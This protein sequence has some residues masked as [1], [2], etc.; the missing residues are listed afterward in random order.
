MTGSPPGALRVMWVLSRVGLSRW[1]GRLSG[2]IGRLRKK[3]RKAGPAARQPTPAK[4]TVSAW[5]TGVFAVMFLFTGINLAATCVRGLG[6]ACEG[7]SPGHFGK[8]GVAPR[9]YKAILEAERAPAGEDE[10]R[11]LSEE[12]S[13]QTG[14]SVRD[15]SRSRLEDAFRLEA[16]RGG[17][18]GKDS[19]ALQERLMDTF[20]K[21]GS[22]GFYIARRRA[23]IPWPSASD[24]P[25]GQQART[26]MVVA[27]AVVFHLLAVAV[28]LLT[29]G[30]KNQDLGK[31]EWTMEWLF[32]FPV[33]SNVLFFAQAMQ[34][35]LLSPVG[36]I[37]GFSL[38]LAA[39]WAAGLSWWALPLAVAA[40]LYLNVLLAAV[41][42]LGETWLRKTFPLGRLKNLQAGFTVLGVFA[43]MGLVLLCSREAWTEWL[44]AMSAGLG[45]WFVWLPFGLPAALAREGGAGAALPLMVVLGVAAPLGAARAA[46]WMVR[47][48]L[49]SHT[50]PL[51]GLR[52]PA[53]AIRF[54]PGRF[55]GII[56]KEMLLLVRDRN[57]LAQTLV[58]PIIVI[59][60]QLLLNPNLLRSMGG[61]FNHS[62]ILAFGIGAYVLMAGAF[63]VLAAEGN[64][65]WLL[66]TF[67][68]RIEKIMMRKALLWSALSSV[69]TLAVLVIAWA[70]QPAVRLEMIGDSALALAGVYIYGFI[71]AGIGVMAT[72]PLA[73]QV[74][75]KIRPTMAYVYMLLASLYAY[76]IYTSSPWQKMAQVVLCSLV[77]YAIWQ[78]V[79]DR[80]PFLLDPTQVPPPRI[81]LS[82]GLIAA[83][84]FFVIQGLLVLAIVGSAPAMFVPGMVIAYAV[85]AGVVW[86]FS[87]LAFRLRKVPRLLRELG[88]AAPEGERGAYGRA[89]AKGLAWG[90]AAAAFGAAYLL[91]LEWI[92]PLRALK[93]HALRSAPPEASAGWG[94][95]L[96]ILAVLV[97][98]L[99][100]EFIFRGLVFRGLRRS[101][102]PA[103]AVF[104]SAAIFAVI[105]PPIS[106]IPVFGLG[107]AAAMSFNSGGLL[108]APIVAHALYNAA[109][110][111]LQLA[112]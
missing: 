4:R 61:Q 100:E 51:Q 104:G 62:A 73:Q 71:A 82:D 54:R 60:F 79:A 77:A 92:G 14:H 95:A 12:L 21:Q 68:Q 69:Y 65:L 33:R 13:E 63:Q 76:G 109:A 112:L 81:A 32:T 80:G 16:V 26:E 85:A 96:A 97:A 31:V 72:N 15:L 19:E 55:R 102:R 78:K 47:D 94:W 105:H 9:T 90:A 57:F 108:V 43:L 10:N 8:L 37:A 110:I 59:G 29:F 22:A 3:A 36:W 5:M 91:A 40:A 28:I 52:R 74:H 25:E 38:A 35:A 2:Q 49:I 7:R 84:V 111:L 101:V 93:E 18:L 87:M 67:P 99:F 86:V 6:R 66:Y 23:P 70:R 83:F 103:A 56:G 75:R 64:S 17:A 98:P 46:G 24:W 27:V 1:L 42:L 48:G 88:L 34:F 39:L 89:A 11:Q 30:S 53:G 44:A 107:L 20:E 106:V 45:D 41:R 58:V 50:G